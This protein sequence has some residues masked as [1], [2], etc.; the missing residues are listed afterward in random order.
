MQIVQFILSVRNRPFFCV[1]SV[2][3]SS[4]LS[5]VKLDNRKKISTVAHILYI[6]GSNKNKYA[7]KTSMQSN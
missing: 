7:G 4:D 2:F 5:S 3:I 6:I 1:L